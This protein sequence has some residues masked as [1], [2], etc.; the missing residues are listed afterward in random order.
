MQLRTVIMGAVGLIHLAPLKS[1]QAK[2][3][4][5]RHFKL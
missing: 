1:F 3:A 2:K 5:H 4:A